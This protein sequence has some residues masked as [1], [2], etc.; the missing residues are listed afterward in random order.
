ML[1]PK[2]GVK[3]QLGERYLNIGKLGGIDAGA[4]FD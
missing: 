2:E 4:A 3:L 1:F